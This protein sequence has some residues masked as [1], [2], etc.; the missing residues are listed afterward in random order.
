MDAGFSSMS[1]L[2]V[3]DDDY[4]RNLL[5]KMLTAIGII[6]IKQAASAAV[7]NDGSANAG[8]MSHDANWRR[9]WWETGGVLTGA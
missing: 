6:D 3:D 7:A 1:I 9:V 2:I 5:T 8:A 4:Q